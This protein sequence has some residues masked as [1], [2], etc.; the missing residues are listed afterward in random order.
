MHASHFLYP[1]ASLIPEIS[2]GAIKFL[3]KEIILANKIGAQR[4]TIHGGQK[5]RPDRET[6]VIKNF[7]VLIRNLKEI[8]K[9]GGKYGIKIGLENSFG[10][11]K[12]CRTPE[13]LLKVINSVKGLGITFDIGHANL[14]DP[15]PV[16][17]FKKIKNFVINSHLHDNNGESD[18]HALIGK[19][20]I[21]FKEF[22]K[23]CKNSNYHGPYIL[24]IFPRENALRG[25]EILLNLWN[26]I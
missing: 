19:G 2:S 11:E 22:L 8:V 4:I 14:V 21:N 23:E 13:D 9:F 16:R 10:S 7:K 25:K 6:L 26:Q 17:Y 18:E 1:I 12:L 24:E 5:D 20:N 3:K 15:N